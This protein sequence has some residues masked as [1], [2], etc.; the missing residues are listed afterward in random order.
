MKKR[1]VIVLAEGFE[2]IEA[3]VP[4]DLLRRAGIDVCIAGINPKNQCVTGSHGISI[5]V[6][7]DLKDL[8]GDFD[9]CIFPGG[10]PGADNL[11]VS[12]YV[13][14][15]IQK[16]HSQKKIIA[17]V[18]ASPAVL[19]APL[20]VLDNRAATCFPGMEDDFPKTTRYTND[21]VA[22]DGHL[23]TSRSAGTAVKFALAII[24]VLINPQAADSVRAKIL[25]G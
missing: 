17:A 16:M 22:V 13:R 9:A 1:A 8:A 20:G 6:D 15:L 25:E 24:Q 11:A 12:E 14:S 2:E 7:T 19:L 5:R 4:I 3:V 21:P 18:C 10:L 23:I